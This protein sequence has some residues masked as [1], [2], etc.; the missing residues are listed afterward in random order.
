MYLKQPPDVAPWEI[1]DEDDSCVHY[2]RTYV[3]QHAQV[4]SKDKLQK[5][6]KAN[7]INLQ[8][9]VIAKVIVQFRKILISAYANRE[10]ELIENVTPFVGV[11]RGWDEKNDR[12][13]FDLWTREGKRFNFMS[14][15]QPCIQVSEYVAKW[16]AP[17]EKRM[18]DDGLAY[19]YDEFAAFFGAEHAAQLWN[20]ASMQ[21]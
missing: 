11:L 8:Y 2:I 3:G 14:S 13:S 17:E 15:G 7:G 6:C 19:T 10:V 4:P 5:F 18:A 21:W 12:F 1:F 9:K 20:E 16:L